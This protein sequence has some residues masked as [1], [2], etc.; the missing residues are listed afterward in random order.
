MGF[1][2][3]AASPFTGGIDLGAEEARAKQLD[4]V[5]A[6]QNASALERGVWTEE[7][8]RDAETRRQQNAADAD[9]YFGDTVSEFAD[10]AVE[11]AKNIADTTRGAV[12]SVAGFTLSTLWRS[13]PWWVWLAGAGYVAWQLGLLKKLR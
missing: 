5:V 3:W 6:R 1:W 4:G 7:Q 8:Y 12:N 2:S 13:L 9:S 11:G 10:G